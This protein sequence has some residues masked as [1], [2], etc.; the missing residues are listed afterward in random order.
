M[1]TPVFDMDNEIKSDFYHYTKSVTSSQR[2][3]MNGNM[4]MPMPS[5]HF[6][7]SSHSGHS[8]ITLSPGTSAANTPI[9]PYYDVNIGNHEYFHQ[10][11][12]NPRHRVQRSGG[13]IGFTK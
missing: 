11:V 6:H 13:S 3:S 10:G 5:Y 8:L 4:L 1:G 2:N 9:S 12:M 7:D